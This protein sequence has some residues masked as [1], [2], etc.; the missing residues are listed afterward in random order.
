MTF[1]E[2]LIAWAFD[3]LLILLAAGLLFAAVLILYIIKT[4]GK[5][6]NDVNELTDEEESLPT[7]TENYPENEEDNIDE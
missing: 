7:M 1:I 5:F 4:S 2:F 6:D 3:C